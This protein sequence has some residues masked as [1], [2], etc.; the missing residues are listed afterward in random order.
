MAWHEYADTTLLVF[1]IKRCG[2]VVAIAYRET[3]TL[4]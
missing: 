2:L 1:T 3:N 4:S